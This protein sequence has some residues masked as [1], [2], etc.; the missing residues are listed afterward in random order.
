MLHGPA[1]GLGSE[2]R[3]FEL[4]GQVLGIDLDRQEVLV[5]HDDIAG[6]MPAMTMPFKVRD[7]MLIRDRTPGDLI[8]ATLE[9]RGSDAY[10]S[11]LTKTGSAPVSEPAP[12]PTASSAFELLKPGEHVPDELFVDQ[13]GREFRISALAGRALALTFIYTRCP[14][15]TFCPLMD[16]Q[17][18][19]LQKSLVQKGL[20]NRVH[21]ISVSFDPSHDTPSVLKQHALGLGADPEVWSFVTG[22][23]DSVDRFARRFGVTITREPDSTDITHN[24]RT[25]VIDPAGKLAV[26]YTGIDWT[27][28]QVLGELERVSE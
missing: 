15:P 4:R 17:F 14:I 23:R 19:M 25:A 18:A 26:V 7:V 5:K 27:P 24:L 8:V 1:C 16:R 28:A 2:A 3:R 12:A 22:D 21:L 13:A 11:S 9:V 20:R 6:F 10:L